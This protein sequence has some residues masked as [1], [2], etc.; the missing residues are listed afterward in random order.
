MSGIKVRYP[1]RFRFVSLFPRISN[2]RMDPLPNPAVYVYIHTVH[3][4]GSISIVLSH[5]N[6]FPFFY[7][8]SV[9][10]S[11]LR[12][13]KPVSY[14]L[15]LD[16]ESTVLIMKHSSLSRKMCSELIHDI[17]LEIVDKVKHSRQNSASV[18][19]AGNV[20]FDIRIHYC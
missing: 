9:V 12:Q 6:M 8:R 16:I 15:Y 20:V 13:R 5:T 17:D 4:G 2:R 18:Q 10:S 3:P 14:G 19:W 7:Q 11:F 1:D